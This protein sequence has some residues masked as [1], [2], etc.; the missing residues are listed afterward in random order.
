M[1]GKRKP[2]ADHILEGTFRDDRHTAT[3]LQP[4][5]E[6]L[7]QPS[8]ML[9]EFA[10]ELF[11]VEVA[12]LNKNR[13]YNPAWQWQIEMM[14]YNIAVAFECMNELKD[15]SGSGLLIKVH[16]QPYFNPTLRLM[17]KSYEHA[18]KIAIQLGITPVAF[19]KFKQMTDE[20]KPTD[21][22]KLLQRKKK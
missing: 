13:M 8:D 14:C 2:I 1:R 19:T 10:R 15:K 12:F 22:Q 20:A 6:Q 16:D 21:L 4:Y 7:P 17:W 5:A 9:N 18:H 11:Y 3:A